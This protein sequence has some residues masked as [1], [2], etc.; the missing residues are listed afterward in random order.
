MLLQLALVLLED[1]GDSAG[2]VTA[3]G[4]SNKEGVCDAC[5]TVDSSKPYW[6]GESCVS[7][8]AGTANAK[9]FLD[10]D[11]CVS[12][13]SNEQFVSM[14]DTTC[15]TGCED[16]YIL[17]DS[18]GIEHKKCMQSSLCDREGEYYYHD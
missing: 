4:C 15:T 13:C 9:P 12:K 14:D 5:T 10:G 6:N 8:A 1:A 17:T 11:Q 2:A 3:P 7:C 18:Y 16:R